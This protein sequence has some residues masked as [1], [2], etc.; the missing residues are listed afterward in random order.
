MSEPGFDPSYNKLSTKEGLSND[1]DVL[2]DNTKTVLDQTKPVP[3]PVSVQMNFPTEIVSLPSEGLVYPKG[4]TLSLGQIEL[5]QVTTKEEEI[6][7]SPNLIQKGLA[8]DKF[9]KELI[10]T[11]INYDDLTLGDKNAIMIA[12]RVLAYGPDYEAKITCPICGESQTKLFNLLQFKQKE[13]DKSIL[14]PTNEYDYILP[15]SKTSIKFKFLT[16]ADEKNIDEELKRMGKLFDK[17]KM[18]DE[19]SH[20]LSVRLKYVITEINGKRDKGSIKLFVDKMN[21][22][23]SRPFRKYLNSITPD[24]NLSYQIECDNPDCFSSGSEIEVTVPLTASF[25]WPDARV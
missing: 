19:P 18:K 14:N 15:D 25:F 1:P 4:S 6:L 20:E 24:I 16:Y 2:Q 9:L 13:I 17:T 3:Q 22:R 11:D 23:D 5:K 7:A 10:I 8:I 21:T 12:A